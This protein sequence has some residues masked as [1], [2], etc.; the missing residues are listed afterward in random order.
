MFNSG[1]TNIK[2]LQAIKCGV[3]LSVLLSSVSVFAESPG[4]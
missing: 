4:T 1:G 3:I 2:L